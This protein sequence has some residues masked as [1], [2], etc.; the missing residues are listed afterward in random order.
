MEN[1]NA[2]P[3]SL[4][5]EE[6]IGLDLDEED[7]EPKLVLSV[8]SELNDESDAPPEVLVDSPQFKRS[9]SLFRD[10]WRFNPMTGS[11]IMRHDQTE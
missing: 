11:P 10:L 4:L 9:Q 1:D 7:I 2:R 6:S 3:V 8:L 5:V